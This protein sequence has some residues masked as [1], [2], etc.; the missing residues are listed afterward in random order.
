MTMKEEA[1]VEI[2][3][4]QQLLKQI[5]GKYKANIVKLIAEDSQRF[6]QLMRALPGVNRQSLTVALR[7]LEE[8]GL[9]E[10]KVIRQKP[11]HVTYCLSA[12]GTALV[13]LLSQLETLIQNEIP[14]NGED[15]NSLQ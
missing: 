11:L 14:K 1:G 10:R 13:P 3:P 15:Q 12:N 2:C 4:I 9:L 6:S 8:A 5:G 7:E